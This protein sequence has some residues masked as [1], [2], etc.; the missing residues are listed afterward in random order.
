MITLSAIVGL[1][2]LLLIH[3]SR[4]LRNSEIAIPIFLD[5]HPKTADFL[6]GYCDKTIQ[7]TS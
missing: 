5:R 7:K 3:S 4:S 1:S 6:E 2:T